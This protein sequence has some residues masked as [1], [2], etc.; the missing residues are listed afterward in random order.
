MT[1]GEIRAVEAG[2]GIGLTRQLLGRQPT[3]PGCL[4]DL[5]NGHRFDS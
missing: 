3:H 4:D 2:E 5:D 1:R